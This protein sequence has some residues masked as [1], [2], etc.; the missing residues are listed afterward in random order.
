MDLANRYQFDDFR[1]YFDY[2]RTLK[3]KRETEG[4]GHF[5][6]LPHVQLVVFDRGVHHQKLHT[7]THYPAMGFLDG[8]EARR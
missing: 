3:L 1:F 6:N 8:W 7:L 4:R 2:T 5:Q